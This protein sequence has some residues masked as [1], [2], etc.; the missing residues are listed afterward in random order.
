[1]KVRHLHTEKG[2]IL[3]SADKITSSSFYADYVQF[4]VCMKRVLLLKFISR[5]TS[6]LPVMCC[7]FF[8][9]YILY[10]LKD[11]A[12]ELGWDEA[13]NDPH[14]KRQV[15]S[16]PKVIGHIVTN[17]LLAFLKKSYVTRNSK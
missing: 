6:V 9:K 8:Q 16:L 10:L 2:I 12:N 15:L 5:L 4:L 1:M 11:I 17:Y 13:K 7:C 3:L 14:L